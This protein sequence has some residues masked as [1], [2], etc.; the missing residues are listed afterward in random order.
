MLI[1]TPPEIDETLT[2]VEGGY[3]FMAGDTLSAIILD[4]VDVLLPPAPKTLRT[5][6]DSVNK[7]GA[8]SIT[9]TVGR[10]NDV[11]LRFATS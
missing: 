4:E 6:L 1:G 11:N 7:E 3:D 8:R 2:S 10:T 5:A 9:A